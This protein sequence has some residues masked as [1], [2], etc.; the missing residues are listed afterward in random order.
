MIQKRGE[1]VSYQ[2]HG[3]NKNHPELQDGEVWLVNAR[4]SFF[5]GSLGWKTKRIGKQA[6]DHKGNPI[7]SAY[8]V[9]P[10]FVQ[11]SEMNTLGV[12]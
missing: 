4:Q 10:V 5:E 7:P 11:E 3:F 1:T 2:G 12:S 9:F 6:Y 8:G